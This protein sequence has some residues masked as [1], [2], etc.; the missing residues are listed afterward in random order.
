MLTI[1]VLHVATLIFV[2]LITYIMLQISMVHPKPIINTCI[3]SSIFQKHVG[4]IKVWSLAG[5]LADVKEV[6]LAGCICN[7]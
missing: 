4:S 7:P 1:L 3:I 2:L 6:Y 5:A